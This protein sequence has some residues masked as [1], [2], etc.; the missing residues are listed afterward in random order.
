MNF[1]SIFRLLSSIFR[2]AP[3][4]IPVSVPVS[5]PDKEPV[6]LTIGRREMGQQEVPG[7]LSNPRIL[8]YHKATS[9]GATSDEV[10][11]CSSFI[12]WAMQQAGL[13]RTESAAARSWL[14]WGVNLAAPAPGCVVVFW[15]GSR[16]AATGHVALFLRMVGDRVEVLGGNQGNSVSVASYPVQ[17]VLGYRWPAEARLPVQAMA[18]AALTD[19]LPVDTMA[20]TLWGEARGEGRPG[21]EAVA[22][23]IMNR[24]RLAGW[25]GSTVVEVCKKPWQFSC[26]N[27]G[28]PNLRKLL[29]VRPGDQAF[30]L[31]LRVARVAVA[32]GLTDTT[33]GAT[34]YYDVRI[35]DPNWVI[36]ATRT[37]DIGHHRF[38]KG[39]K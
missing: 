12:N 11:W 32:G 19:S 39:V 29:A 23:V 24:V 14:D 38:F 2:P 25:M 9:L 17:Q 34:H 8:E 4:A 13:S 28:D 1:A 37:C 7:A 3:V 35:P 27:M 30:D 26:W 20:R 22:S 5:V 33:G 36:G 18:P 10:P 31:C 16:D 21:I 15:R 6:W